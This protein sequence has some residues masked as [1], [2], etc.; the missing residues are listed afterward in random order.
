MERVESSRRRPH[1]CN[2]ERTTREQRATVETSTAN[3]SAKNKGKRAPTQAS[4]LDAS[5]P[6]TVTRTSLPLPLAPFLPCPHASLA[7]ALPV[8]TIDVDYTAEKGASSVQ[9]RVA[10]H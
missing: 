7:M 2:P 5:R 8:I 10:G 4:D 3:L 6:V 1:R 9:T